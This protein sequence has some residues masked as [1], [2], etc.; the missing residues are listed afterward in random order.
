MSPQTFVCGERFAAC[1]REAGL[2][3]GVFE[4]LVIDHPTCSLVA[5]HPAVQFIQFTGSLNGG[6]EIAKA[7]NGRFIHAQYEMGGKGKAGSNYF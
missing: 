5:Q 4:H 3:E 1:I 7:V 2:P 6:K